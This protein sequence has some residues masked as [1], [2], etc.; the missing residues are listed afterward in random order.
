MIFN[1]T[2]QEPGPVSCAPTTLLKTEYDDI[3][4][5]KS[6]NFD[7]QVK[8][9]K[10]DLYIRNQEN[11]LMWQIEQ[12][13]NNVL[14]HMTKGICEERYPGNPADI[15]QVDKNLSSMRAGDTMYVFDCKEKLGKWQ[16]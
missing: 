16:L 7:Q 2:G 8:E 5:T 15:I 4:L 9:V 10:I 11:Y 1:I 14:R 6:T 13:S 3:Y 12:S